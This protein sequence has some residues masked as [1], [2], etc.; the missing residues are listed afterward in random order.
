MEEL[1]LVKSMLQSLLLLLSI[2]KASIQSH[3]QKR[4]EHLNFRRSIYIALPF[5]TIIY[6][7]TNV[8]YFTELSHD[9]MINSNAVAISFAYKFNKLFSYTIPFFVGCS[10]FGGLN[11]T[12]L[13]VPRMCY[14]AGRKGDL[15]QIFSLVHSTNTPGFSVIFIGIVYSC[16]LFTE[17][18]DSLVVAFTFVESAAILACVMVLIHIRWNSSTKSQIR[19]HISIIYI[20]F[21]LQSIIVLLA[22]IYELRLSIISSFAFVSGIPLYYFFIYKKKNQTIFNK[23]LNKFTIQYQK[24]FLAVPGIMYMTD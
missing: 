7:L 2:I 3:K 10:T 22:L 21:V 20:F 9:E 5:V 13:S 14:V 12:L 4:F 24:L 17:S 16:F 19:V 15:P 23:L 8:A 6:F 1:D 11:G 18:V